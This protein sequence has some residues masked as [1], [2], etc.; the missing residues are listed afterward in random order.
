MQLVIRLSILAGL[1]F[2]VE[3]A[4]AVGDQF[5]WQVPWYFI[6]DV[7]LAGLP[8]VWLVRE[9]MPAAPRA[10][11]LAFVTTSSLFVALASALEL[12]A[13]ANR[14]WWFADKDPMTGIQV[15]AVPVEEFL[16]YPLFL[17]LPILFYLALEKYVPA[18]ELPPKALSTSAT[19]LFRALGVVFILLGIGLLVNAIRTTI[20]PIDFAIVPS[21]DAAGAFRYSTGPRQMSWTVVQVLSLGTVSLLWPYLKPRVHGQR[22]LITVCVFF[23]LSLYFELVGCGRG[24]WVWNEQQVLGVFT[25]VLPIDSYIMYFTGATTTIFVFTLVRPMFDVR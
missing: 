5:G 11:Q 22:L 10:T 3:M 13:I 19:W 9:T 15:G 6:H 16:F 14:Y 20:P 24:W 7:L 18:S 23:V 2:L 12:V 4:Q 21:V 1:M 25:W 17:N 8:M